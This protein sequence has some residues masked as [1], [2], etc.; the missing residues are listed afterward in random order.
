MYRSKEMIKSALERDTN[1]RAYE[2]SVRQFGEIVMADPS[3]IKKL[4]TTKDADDFLSTYCRLAAEQGINFTKDELRVV[5]QEQKT[6]T[7]WLIPKAVLGI[8]REIL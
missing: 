8:A 6:G 1:N 5:V 3:I 4:E 2:K 7:N